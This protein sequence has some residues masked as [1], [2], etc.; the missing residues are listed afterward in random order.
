[1]IANGVTLRIGC[2]KLRNRQRNDGEKG[3][4]RVAW[5]LGGDRRLSNTV[6]IIDVKR[7][8]IIIIIIRS[9]SL[10]VQHL[11][12][13]LYISCIGSPSLGAGDHWW[14]RLSSSSTSNT[15]RPRPHN[16]HQIR[17]VL[18]LSECDTNI[19]RLSHT[20]GSICNPSGI[21]LRSTRRRTFQTERCDRR[22]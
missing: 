16:T 14:T 17:L 22:P 4:K 13:T 8:A 20:R 1:M 3:K 21:S 7:R 9:T 11:Y 18:Q 6:I 19:I 12:C 5:I 2:N 10:P 15:L